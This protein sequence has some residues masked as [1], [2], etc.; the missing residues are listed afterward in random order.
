VCLCLH[1]AA[2]A[3]SVV[4]VTDTPWLTWL[5]VWSVSPQLH[6]RAC[7]VPCRAQCSMSQ[8][9]S[10]YE[11]WSGTAGWLVTDCLTTEMCARR[12]MLQWA[13]ARCLLTVTAA[14]LCPVSS[15][16]ATCSCDRPH[17]SMWSCSSCV[18]AANSKFKRSL[19]VTPAGTPSR[20]MDL[21]RKIL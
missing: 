7:T 11:C 10:N 15:R 21:V 20:D 16:L 12:L 6:G 1:S 18:K 13:C 14:Q 4:G 19:S 2:S 9:T 3:G 17:D 8:E 5:T